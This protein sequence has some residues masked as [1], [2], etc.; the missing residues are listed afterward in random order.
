MMARIASRLIMM[1]EPRSVGG[2]VLGPNAAGDG[3]RGCGA[4]LSRER[5]S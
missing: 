4:F 3:S 5:Q 2:S 1:V